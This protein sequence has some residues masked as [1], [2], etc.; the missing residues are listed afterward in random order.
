[1]MTRARADTTVA[2]HDA[3]YDAAFDP[4]PDPDDPRPRLTREERA[5]HDQNVARLRRL[6]IS[7]TIFK[8]GL[9]ALVAALV[10]RFL[11][12]GAA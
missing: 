8:I 3:A 6:L 2:D 4:G 10:W 7:F 5:I 9:L 1:M 12:P 11:G